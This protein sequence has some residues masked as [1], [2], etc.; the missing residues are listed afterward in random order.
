MILKNFLC[1][2]ESFDVDC[3]RIIAGGG[4]G[5][6]TPRVSNRTF[7]SDSLSSS[8]MEGYLAKKKYMYIF[9]IDSTKSIARFSLNGKGERRDYALAG[10]FVV[11]IPKQHCSSWG[12]LV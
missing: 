8:T 10:D 12:C 6:E 4:L 11:A 7:R 5:A 9:R 2:S 1:V 3:P